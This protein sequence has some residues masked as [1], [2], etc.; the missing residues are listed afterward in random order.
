MHMT[1][2]AVR[3]LPS[4]PFETYVVELVADHLDGNEQR[5]QLK[6]VFVSSLGERVRE[7]T[8][9]PHRIHFIFDV[10]ASDMKATLQALMALVPSATI[11]QIYPREFEY[12]PRRKK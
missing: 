7:A 8:L 10:P 6:R 1:G 5:N 4:P 3:A 2:S 11:N 12:T 9:L